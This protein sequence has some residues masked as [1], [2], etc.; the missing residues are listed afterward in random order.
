MSFQKCKVKGMGVNSEAYH[1]Q[2]AKRG[3][4]EFILS[5]SSIKAF[6]ECPSRW[7]AGYESPDSDAKDYGNLLDVLVLTPESFQ[8]RFSVKPSTYP[9]EPA[10][11]GRGKAAAKTEDAAP[12]AAPKYTLQQAIDRAKDIVGP[13]ESPTH[14]ANIKVLSELNTRWGIGKVRELPPEKID[15]YMAELDAQFPPSEA[16]APG[17]DLF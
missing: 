12:A 2:E 16:K 3:T 11:K 8:E 5:P 7:K 1:N 6:A 17:A 13:K 9:A 4:A 10:K 15:G 14:D